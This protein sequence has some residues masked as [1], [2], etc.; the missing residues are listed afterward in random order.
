MAV[1]NSVVWKERGRKS[2][3]SGTVKSGVGLACG[4]W[5][6][7]VSTATQAQ[8]D[9][10]DDGRV[11]VLNGAQDIGTGTRTVMA[12]VAAEELG[13]SLDAITVKLGD[14]DWPIGPG[15][16]GSCTAASI[17]PAVRTAAYQVKRKLLSL[18]AKTLKTTIDDLEM[19]RGSVASKKDHSKSLSWKQLAARI[20][21]GKLSVVA[22]R[23]HDYQALSELTGG[24]QIA[25][26]EV[27]TATG[28]VR[29]KRVSAVHDFGR[30]INRMTA[31]SQIN[32][33]IIQGVSYALFEDRV[34]DEKTGRMVNPDL[35][36]YKIATVNDCPEIDV[37]ILE[38]FNGGNATGTVGLGEPPT[39]P[40]A[41]AI[42]NAV[43]DAIGVRVLELPITPARVLAALANRGREAS[44]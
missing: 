31:E 4:V 43:A 3:Q 29:V 18:A 36:S 9:V 10:H 41:A 1:A 21:G 15:S 7:I 27:D 2:K 11:E 14:T 25:E 26:V 8:I 35:E 19:K 17:A 23:S 13:L 12:Q 39:V 40:T 20:P 28:S 16:G 30:P 22:D 6:K 34:L 44:R 42:A 32:G 5:Y 33:G 38:V 37:T 24:V